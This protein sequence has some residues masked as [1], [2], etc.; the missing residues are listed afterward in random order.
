MF[1]VPALRHTS[2]ALLA[3]AGVHPKVM[4]ERF[5]HAQFSTTM[6]VYGHLFPT[7]QD[8]AAEKL[9][10]MLTRPAPPTTPP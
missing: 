10:K 5:G 8:E 9:N 4:Q 2:A 3:A 7:M 1:L 6:D